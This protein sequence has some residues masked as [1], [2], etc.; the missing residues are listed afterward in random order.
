ME[1]RKE[2]RKELVCTLDALGPMI[3]RLVRAAG[4]LG[5]HGREEGSWERGKGRG[6]RAGG[7]RIFEIN[8]FLGE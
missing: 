3:L 1:G 8:L 2:W 5:G 4:R 7:R 6:G